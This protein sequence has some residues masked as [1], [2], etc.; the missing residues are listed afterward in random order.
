M[1]VL[2]CARAR[3]S[4]WL[5]VCLSFLF[6]SRAAAVF[7]VRWKDRVLGIRVGDFFQ[8][9]KRAGCHDTVAIADR[10]IVLE[11][12]MSSRRK[13]RAAQGIGELVGFVPGCRSP[14]AAAAAAI[15]AR[16]PVRPLI[17]LK[18]LR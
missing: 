3:S 13:P 10:V 5:S 8:S 16:P 18:H 2:A 14:T 11:D 12:A 9:T 4:A 17:D 7:T 1:R 15:A 6:A